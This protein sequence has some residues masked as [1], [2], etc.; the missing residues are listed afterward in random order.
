[1]KLDKQQIQA[2]AEKISREIN[3]S[4]A[5]LNK[6]IKVKHRSLVEKKLSL[7]ENKSLGE[8]F[9]QI[10]GSYERNGIVGYIVKK[11][12]SDFD[13]L[14]VEDTRK[15][16]QDQIRTE[17]ILETIESDDLKEIVAKIK[18]KYV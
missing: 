9:T 6:E 7:K 18:A 14:P 2:L 17:I 4:I 15:V 13:K 3:D 16:S 8:Y 1:M 10:S 5:N 12:Q 11:Y